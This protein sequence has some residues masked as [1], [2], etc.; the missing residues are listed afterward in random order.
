MIGALL[1]VS[2][3]DVQTMAARTAD[4]LTVVVSMPVRPP[5]MTI[6]GSRTCRFASESFLKPPVS[7]SAIRKS[8][9]LRTPRMRLFLTSM[10][11]GLPAP[12]ASA[13]WSKPSSKAPSTSRVPPK[14]TPP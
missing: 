6:A 14:R 12:A 5:P 2:L 3:L 1:F 8:D 7:C 13:T 11:V 10:I 9:A 4:E